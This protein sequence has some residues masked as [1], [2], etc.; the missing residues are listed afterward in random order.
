MLK[1]IVDLL[2]WGV[3]LQAEGCGSELTE[4]DGHGLVVGVV[5]EFGRVICCDRL[6]LFFEN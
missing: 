2:P 6:S 1:N 3:D 5:F 4:R